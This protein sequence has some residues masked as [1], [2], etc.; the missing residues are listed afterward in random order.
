MILSLVALAVFVLLAFLRVSAIGWLLAFMVFVPALALHL[1]ISDGA[2]Q[3]I[4]LT[5]LLLVLLFAVPPIRRVAVTP[6]ILWL[7]RRCL[8]SAYATEYSAIN[9]G[10]VWWEGELFSG[11]P[12]WDKL[13][14][15]PRCGLKPEEQSFLDNETEQLCNMLNDWKI[16]HEHLDMPPSVWAFLREKGFFGLAIPKCYGGREFSAQAHSAI[17]SKLASRS[18]TAA[19]TVMVPNALGPADLLL[20]FGTAVQKDQYLPRLARGE[21]VPCLALTGLFSGGDADAMPDVGEICRA[22]FGGE[23]N[24]LGIRLNWDKRYTTLAPVAT[25]LG[26]AF[27]LRDP[28]RLLGGEVDRGLTLALVPAILPGVE[29]GRRHFPLNTALLN[30]PTRGRDVF[31]PLEFL[32]GGLSH[33]GQGRQMLQECLLA[34]RALSL[35]ASSTGMMQLAA[36]SSGAYARVR[37]KPAAPI[38]YFGRIEEPLA[39]IAANTYLIDAARRMTAL[40]VDIGEKPS[41]ISAVMKHHA[42]ER[43]RQ[44]INDAMDIVGSKGVCLGPENLLGRAYQQIPIG[45]TLEGA[46]LML[47][48]RRIFGYE[49]LR[50][51]PYLSREIAAIRES[52]PQQARRQF[53]QAFFGHVGFV[54]NNAAR[55][56]VF[57]IFGMLIPVQRGVGVPC[58][59]RKLT[60]YTAAFALCTDVAIIT[61]GSGLNRREKLTA[62]LGDVLSLLYL[63]SAT[64]KRFEDEGR[65]PEDRPLLE[66]TMQDTLWRIQEAL[67]D[68]LRNLPFWPLRAAL[69]VLLF[70]LGCRRTPPSDAL[71]HRLALMLMRRGGTRDRLTRGMYVPEDENEPLGA[72][73]AALASTVECEI[74][75]RKLDSAYRS[76][77]LLAHDEL[78]RIAEARERGLIGPEQAL[79]LERDYTLRCKVGKVD[80][81]E[82]DALRA[83][84]NSKTTD[85][86]SA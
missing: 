70:P 29:I 85:K 17:I 78:A 2:L 16:T 37:Q 23:R 30:G 7:F 82:I 12:D 45:L 27:R 77:G 19:M 68:T 44:V 31:I 42:T 69:H 73:E 10:T 54:F 62:R 58:H 81:F 49:A 59:F 40:A 38:E 13:L 1:R 67:A 47:P 15:L 35:S 84:S 22:D 65:Q 79:R 36:R 34:G 86:D 46:N 56:V 48:S 63:G 51:H 71:D 50:A 41:V 43:A 76:G 14:A 57:S 33:I 32:I 80:E 3:G 28:E 21:E 25:L 39:R 60:R 66:W 75:Q 83:V 55:S 64:L 20:R 8:P 18:G 5:L 53:D 11:Y 26:L 72:L 9:S 6:L 61:L 74:L 4:Y 52:D 24:V